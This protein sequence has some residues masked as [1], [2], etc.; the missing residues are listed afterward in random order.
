MSKLKTNREQLVI[1]S[2]IGEISSPLAN[3]M[4]PYRISADGEPMVL[5]GVGGIT[6]NKRVGDSAIDLWG[7]HIEPAVSVKNPENPPTT[8]SNGALNIYA[9]VGD[10]ARVINGDAKN[11]LGRVTGKH[12]G[13]E[14]VLVDF[15]L[16]QMEKMAIGDK[17]QVKAYGQGLAL[18][19]FPDVKL[20]NLSPDLLDVM[21]VKGNN[22]TGRIQVHVTHII[23]AAVM[24]SGLGKNAVVAGDYD[25]QMFDPE[26]VAEHH[27]NDLRFGDI[28]AITDAD[29]SFGRIYRQKAM[30]IGVIV[31]SRSVVA[32]HGPGVTTL[33]T[34]KVGAI[35]A[36][37]HHKANLKD[38]FGKMGEIHG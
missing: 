21:E 24:G 7:D 4:L 9:C 26:T 33:M 30:S 31:H 18:H 17:I 20:S 11:E 10:I 27:M 6:F 35:E 13:I 34:S 5:P 36:I 16:E 32:G 38:Y 29:H 8:G 37:I 12:G 19:D 25:I 22:K 3:S 28:V 15:T 1:Q 14:H 23:P 2:V